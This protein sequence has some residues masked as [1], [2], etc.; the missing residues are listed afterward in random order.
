MEQTIKAIKF[1]RHSGKRGVTTIF[2]VNSHH[3][4]K[5]NLH[6][7]SIA[8]F[9]IA[10]TNVDYLAKFKDLIKD[11]GQQNDA[12]ALY[13]Y[14]YQRNTI[15]MVKAKYRNLANIGNGIQKFFNYSYKNKQQ[16]AQISILLIKKDQFDCLWKEAHSEN[17]KKSTRM[18]QTRYSTCS[19][20]DDIKNRKGIDEEKLTL[21]AEKFAGNSDVAK[22]VRLDILIAACHNHPVLIIG[23]TGSGKNIVAR[24]IHENS[25]PAKKNIV[26]INCGA[27][28]S[29]LIHSELFGHRKGAFTG[30]T[31]DRNGLIQSADKGT[32]F[33]DEIGDMPLDQQ[34]KVLHVLENGTYRRIGEEKDRKVDIRVVAATNR[35]LY[36]MVRTGRFRSDLL[37]RLLRGTLIRT[38]CLRDHI[39]DIAGLTQYLWAKIAH[40]DQPRPPLPAEIIDEL[41]KYRWPGNVRE[42]SSVLC[43]LDSYFG[44]ND[45]SLKHLQYIFQIQGQMNETSDSLF[46]SPS[47]IKPNAPAC[48]RHLKQAEESIRSIQVLL[49]PIVYNQKSFSGSLLSLSNIL[50]H[51]LQ[52][53]ETFFLQPLLFANEEAFAVTNQIKGSLEYFQSL[54]KEGQ[55][56][57]AQHLLTDKIMSQLD[58]ALIV[59]SN[60]AN[61]LIE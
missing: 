28:S 58:S 55:L 34:V 56:I 21:L 52:T 9:L 42:L 4:I 36:A 25:T 10:D 38:P 2:D 7:D 30:A 45:L 20:V 12:Q 61:T 47:T 24:A 1:D 23:E 16:K 32:L 46:S 60:T 41:K 18:P 35:D 5:Q 31:R 51:R 44:E 33:L 27:I 13:R 54:T 59:L 15:P 3:S 19:I 8:I 43:G 40:P 14:F 26:T 50:S 29:E 6:S 49:E 17:Q 53:L 39:E 22:K 37:Y 11:L 57:K 48:L